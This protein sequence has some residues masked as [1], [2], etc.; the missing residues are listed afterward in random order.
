MRRQHRP[1][2]ADA[3]PLRPLHLDRPRLTT[4]VFIN[5]ADPTGRRSAR[6]EY[7]KIVLGWIV[8]CVPR[9]CAM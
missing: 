2:E 9:S 4:S 3:G 1:D 6:D 7:M 5:D 8:E